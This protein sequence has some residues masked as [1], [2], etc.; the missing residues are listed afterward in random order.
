MRYAGL[1]KNDIIDGI[2]GISVSLWMQGCPH[3]CKGCHNPQTWDFDGGIETS[4]E[5]LFKSVVENMNSNGVKRNLSILG[6]EPLC[7]ENLKY[8]GD[9]VEKI[10]TQFPDR[11][12]IVWTGYKY[13][14]LMK[15]KRIRSVLKNIDY[16]IDGNFIL[17]KRD[18]TLKLRGSSNQRIFKNNHRRYFVSFKDVTNII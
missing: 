1:I 9:I 8:T 16:L 12:I 5:L 15:N 10:K 3:H 13:E 6:G 17:E 7:E 4:F 14:T 2:D 11:K 18:I